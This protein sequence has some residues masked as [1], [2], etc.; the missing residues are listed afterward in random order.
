MIMHGAPELIYRDESLLAVSK[1]SGWLSIPDRHDAELPSVRKWMEAKG[2]K[3]F[4]VHRIDKDTS[5]LLL[6]ARNEA[7]HRYYNN[8][9]QQ[10]TLEKNYFGL[11]VGAFSEDEGIYDQ[12]IEEHP[13]I[14]GKMRVGRKGKSAITHY[15]VIERFRNYAWVGFR[16]E[17]GRT[18]QIR[19]HLQN[20]GHALVGDPLYGSAAPLLL[21]SIKKKFNLSKK[22]EEER[23]ILSRLALHAS[24][25][26]LTSME[27]TPLSVEAPLTRDLDATLKQLRKWGGLKA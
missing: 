16:I 12:P 13:V 26:A 4:V 10:R 5:G 23:P 11:V 19:V 17:T 27:G 18:H 14:P 20:A 2:E 7:A 1:P 9:F 8:L 25:V 22:E 24:S 21:S 6:F 3:V 15:R